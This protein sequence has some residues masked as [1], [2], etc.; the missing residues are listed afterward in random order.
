MTGTG[1]T[2]F[3]NLYT[4]P[5]YTSIWGDG[6]GGSVTIAGSITVPSNGVVSETRIVY[7]FIAA[8]QNLPPGSYATATPITITI[9]NVASTTK[10]DTFLVSASIV[11]QCYVSA[12]NLPFGSV[13]PLSSQTDASMTMTVSCTRTTPTP[14]D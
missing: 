2:L 9:A 14:S 12:P 13:N 6:S 8:G 4:S 11:A 1:G 7:G 5:A 3:Y 10:T